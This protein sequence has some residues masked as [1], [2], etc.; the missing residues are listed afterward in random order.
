[1]FSLSTAY[2]AVSITDLVTLIKTW[3]L[4]PDPS[5]SA[6]ATSPLDDV[7]LLFN[8]L[9]LINVGGWSSSHIVG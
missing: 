8:A 4:V 5:D 1:M 6:S 7:L 3:Y 9:A 2:F